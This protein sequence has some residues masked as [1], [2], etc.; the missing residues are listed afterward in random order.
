MANKYVGAA[1]G[2]VKLAKYVAKKFIKKDKG[3][4]ESISGVAPGT[5]L[6]GKSVSQVKMDAS[7]SKIKSDSFEI[8]QR[9]TDAMKKMKDIKS[10]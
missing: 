5:D 1:Q 3:G 10:K 9:V 4:V 6:G 8:K 2:A 7:I